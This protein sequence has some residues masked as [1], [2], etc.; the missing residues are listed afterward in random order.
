MC[1]IFLVNNLFKFFSANS[2]QILKLYSDKVF[3]IS[4]ISSMRIEVMIL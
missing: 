3:I 1:L 4:N 2:Q